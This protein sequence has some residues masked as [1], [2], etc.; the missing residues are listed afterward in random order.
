MRTTNRWT[1][2]PMRAVCTLAA[3]FGALLGLAVSGPAG[4]PALAAGLA[5]APAIIPQ[6][7]VGGLT[8]PVAI[9]STGDGSG[10]LFITQQT[11]QIVIYDGT[12][13]LPAPFLDIS[14]LIASGSEQGLL[15]VAFHP[16]YATNGFF[17]VDYTRKSDGAT[18]IARYHVPP[19]NPNVADPASAQPLLTIAQPESNH[20]GG[21]LQFGPD[22]YLYIGMGDGGGADDQHGTIGNGQDLSQLL[23][24]LLRIDVDHGSPYAIPPGNPFVDGNPNT[25]D[26]IWAYGLRNPWRFSFDRQTGDLFIGDVGQSSREEID[27]HAAGSAGGQNY[28]WRLMEG[29]LCHPVTSTCNSN[30]SLTL[31]IL[32]YNTHDGGTCAVTGGYRYRGA[33]FPQLWGVY[34]YADYCSGQIWGATSA[35]NGTWTADPLLDTDA[36]IS[37]FGEDQAGELYFADRAGGVIYRIIVVTNGVYLP[38]LGN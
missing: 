37:T 12:H 31:P 2:T 19:G 1:A 29:S 32:E 25:R 34:F 21:Q 8:D 16:Q 15:S 38:L 17:Y 36:F 11:G 4:H 14:R 30:H 35:G 7:V 6:P 24:K 22:G 27:F 10:R 5:G 18:V 26:E 28:G 20:N 23:G 3:V 13:I 9:T 33:R